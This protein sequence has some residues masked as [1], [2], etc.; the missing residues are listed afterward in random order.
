MALR[1][2]LEIVGTIPTYIVE[3]YAKEQSWIQS[4][5]TSSKEYVRDLA[6]KIYAV[7]LAYVPTNEFENHISKM[8]K[9]TKDKVLENQQGAILALSYSMERKLILRRSEDKNT[10]VNW[11]TY[12]D[13]VKAICKCQLSLFFKCFKIWM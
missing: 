9:T 8:L 11:N 3:R 6:A 12:I 7:F 5:L 1:A 10:L 4:L 2:W 13:T